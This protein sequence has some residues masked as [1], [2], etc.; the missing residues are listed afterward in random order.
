ML[1]DLVEEGRKIFLFSQ[2]TS[3][4]ELVATALDEAHIP[5][6]CSQ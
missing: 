2:F 1:P 6:R 4:L 5:Y 3:M